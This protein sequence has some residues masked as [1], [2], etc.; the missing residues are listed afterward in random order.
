M[1]NTNILVTG[2]AGFIG[3]HL[4]E[5]LCATKENKVFVI[6]NCSTGSVDNFEGRLNYG[7]YGFYEYDV[8]NL[9]ELEEVFKIV[10][11]DQVYHLA[12]HVGY[13]HVLKEPIKTI[14]EN[15][16]M[17]ENICKLCN[18]SK[19]KLLFTSSSEV[20][21]KNFNL[22]YNEE[23]VSIFPDPSYI[24]YGYALSKLT[25]EY[26]IKAYLK[27]KKLKAVI[28]RLFNTVGPR[29]SPAYGMVIPRF[30]KQAEAGEDLTV[31]GDGNQIRV[32]KWAY[33]FGLG[34]SN[35]PTATNLN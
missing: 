35:P 3:S 18:L 25:S 21:G 13:F 6:D 10:K 33:A 4:V 14:E 28:T 2:G 27:Q 34:G 5:E 15:I 17:T 20:Y 31:Y 19:S 32:K 16:R 1:S 9:K 26:I 8:S 7:L 11:P 23:E 30:I 12:S 29:Q 22:P 24:K